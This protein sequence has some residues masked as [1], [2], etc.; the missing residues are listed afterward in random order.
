MSEL[1]HIKGMEELRKYLR[2]FPLDVQAKAVRRPTAIAARELRDDVKGIAP[3]YHGDVAEGHPPPG[4]LRKSIQI[5]RMPGF[6][7]DRCLYAVFVR[8]GRG[9]S[10]KKNLNL[11]A[12]YW[13]FVEFGTAKMG[14]RPFMRPAFEAHKSEILA[15]Q[16]KELTDS[17]FKV[18]RNLAWGRPWNA[19]YE[20]R[21][22]P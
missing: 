12:F 7:P 2:T 18:A 13:W 3:M 6:P 14:A 15:T 8:K 4:T 9:R 16:I 17:V 19:V 22:R 10:G 20:T 5:R 21:V 1:V 11:D